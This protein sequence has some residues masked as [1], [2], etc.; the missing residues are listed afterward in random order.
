ME[1]LSE[2]LS[3]FDDLELFCE[4]HGIPCIGLCSNFL[5]KEKIKFLCMKC[6]KSGKT[7]ITKEKHELITLSEMLYRFFIKEE[8]KS[9]DLLEIQ[10]MNQIIREYEKGELNN[11][12]SQF[13]II[14][15]ESSEKMTEIQMAF[16]KMID[17]LVNDFK[18]NNDMKLE[19]ISNLTKKKSQKEEDELKL[20]LN[21]K[22]PEFDKKDMNHNQK[23]IDFMN[24][25]YKL[26]SPKNFINSVKFLSDTKKF[27]E[28]AN[29]LNKKL[30]ANDVTIDNKEK[31]KKMESKIDSLLSE[32]EAKFD[33]KLSQIENEIIIPKDSENIYSKCSSTL[34]F[35]KNPQELIYKE[36][37]CS[38]AHKTNS[39]DKVFCAFKS[40]GGE[41]LIVWGTP[42]YNIEFYDMEK[43]KIIKTIHR[44]HNQTVFSCRHYPDTKKRIDY[45]ISSSYDRTVKVWDIK[46]YSYIVNITSAHSGYYI[47]SVS[48]L[49]DEKEDSNYIITSAPNEYMK[50]WDFSGKYIRKLGQNDESTYFIDVYYDNKEKKNYILNANSVDV[51]S[52]TFKN[53]E[54]Y[55]KYKG[56]PQ[57]WHM[58]ALVN[59]VKNQQI[60][61]ESDGN[62]YIRMWE[63]HTAIII[64]C[65]SSSPTLNLRGICLWN[66]DYLFAAGNDYQVKLFDLTNG[67]FLKSFKGHTSTVCSL[68][69]VVHPKYGESLISQGLDGKLK[70]WVCSQN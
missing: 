49:C 14:K 2:L 13:K 29:N 59:E 54:L 60:L 45:L 9:I 4:E 57:T 11:I 50:V 39:I 17:F 28:V 33:E 70:L 67:K 42:Q 41:S 64:K 6:I 16:I 5:C 62:G 25:G 51:K 65:I 15:E 23:L 21:I 26:S 58:S 12:L 40:F 53:G 46:T 1:S 68:D 10:T 18:H 63:F 19:E 27:S 31:K 43:Q 30:Y 35:V 55:H 38:S 7:C 37:I 20:I 34:K 44:A 61:I 48:V 3:P 32:L 56:S 66:D 52:Y 8:N 47:Y 22:M 36:D 24:N 69:K